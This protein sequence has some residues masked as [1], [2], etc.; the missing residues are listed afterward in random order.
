MKLWKKNLKKQIFKKKTRYSEKNVLK[1]HSVHAF[2]KKYKS[3]KDQYGELK[4]ILDDF[5]INNET[6]EQYRN[7]LIEIEKRINFDLLNIG[8]KKFLKEIDDILK[9]HSE[10]GLDSS[11]L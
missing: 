2:L 8:R 9:T 3:I 1:L 10:L 6:F 5:Q 7:I 4:T 11:A